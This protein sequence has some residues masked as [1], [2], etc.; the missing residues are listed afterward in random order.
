MEI[1]HFLGPDS[2]QTMLL[3][4]P[5]FEIF[6]K[7]ARLLLL[8]LH[9]SPFNLLLVGERGRGRGMS[10]ALGEVAGVI[11]GWQEKLEVVLKKAGESSEDWGA[12]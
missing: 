10:E 5:D 1:Q 6:H 11:G 2:N 8:I 4:S 9:I 7:N 12:L 3:L